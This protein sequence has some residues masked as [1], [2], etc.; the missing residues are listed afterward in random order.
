M[1]SRRGLNTTCEEGS[2]LRLNVFVRSVSLKITTY[3][4]IIYLDCDQ[5]RKVVV[6]RP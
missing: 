6:S 2:L 1:T 5:S 3:I 4:V